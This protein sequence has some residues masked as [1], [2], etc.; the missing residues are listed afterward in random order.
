MEEKALSPKTVTELKQVTPEEICE[1]SEC[2]METDKMMNQ[3]T[4]ELEHLSSSLYS[5]AETKKRYD[6]VSKKVRGQMRNLVTKI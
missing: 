5:L 6:E 2:V 4:E 1:L 3:S